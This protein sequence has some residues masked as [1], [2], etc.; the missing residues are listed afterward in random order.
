MQTFIRKTIFLT[1]ATILRWPLLVL[2]YLM[3]KTG[4]FKTVFLV[5]ATN[6][7]ELLN[8]YPNIFFLRK[9]L[10]GKPTPVGLIMKG[11]LPIGLYLGIPDLP[12]Q[13]ALKRNRYL[14]EN[15]VEQMHWFRRLAG[16]KTIGLA[17][18]LGPIFSGRHNLPMEAPIFTS[19]FG[20]VFSIHEAINWVARQR[21][22]FLHRQKIAIV[23]GGE[24]SVTLREY[25]CN[26]GYDCSMVEMKYTLR[27]KVLPVDVKR[28]R[29][30]LHGIDFI[31]NLMPTGAD[32]IDSGV[33]DAIPRE[34]TIVD[35]SRPVIPVE[36]LVQKVYMGNRVRRSGMRFVCAL[37][38][39][40]KQTELPAC[41]L[42]S[43]IAAMTAKNT[44]NLESFCLLARRQAFSTALVD[45]T[46]HI[47]KNEK[48]SFWDGLGEDTVDNGVELL[49]QE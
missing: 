2:I 1:V 15:I 16:A 13:L 14:A 49:S 26:Q 24:L 10:S 47:D 19:T 27:G 11:W 23:G 42:P 31:V 33:A 22:S 25:L 18:Q 46:T 34:V 45:A 38:G 4:V 6:K 32:F 7:N 8:V 29:D 28:N 3:G 12:G 17:G 9:Y 37:P 40:W 43:I 48:R 20:N 5:Y 39:G 21:N 36:K 44:E 35:F 41:A 30:Q